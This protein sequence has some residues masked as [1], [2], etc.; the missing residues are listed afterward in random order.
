MTS[1]PVHQGGCY[2][3]RV[4]LRFDTAPQS[5]IHCHCGQCRR[6]SGGAFTTWISVARSALQIEGAEHL[7]AFDATA[8]V[9]RHFCRTC[10]THVYTGDRRLPEVAGLPAG[11][12]DDGR[13]VTPQAHYFVDDRTPWHVPDDGLPWYGGATGYERVK[14]EP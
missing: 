7:Q 10:G 2:C 1:T 8:N 4:R 5:V 6:L 13:V 14:R 3:G 12:V 9:T 11:V